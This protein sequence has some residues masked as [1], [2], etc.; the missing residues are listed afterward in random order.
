MRVIA[1]NDVH[2]Q[3]LNTRALNAQPTCIS[4]NHSFINKTETAAVL[5]EDWGGNCWV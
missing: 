3:N 2:K 1:H 4:R 5:T